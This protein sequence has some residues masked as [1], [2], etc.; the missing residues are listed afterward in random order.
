MEQIENCNPCLSSIN[1]L[2]KTL[3]NEQSQY[4]EEQKIC[5]EYKKGS[6]LYKETS[7]IMGVYC[8]CKGV[9]K[10]YKTGSD[11]KEQ[12][13]AFA[14][15]GDITGYRSILSNEAACTTAE[16]IQNAIVCQIPSNVII[17]LVKTNGNFAL[18]L[19]KLTCRELNQAN[20]FI[21]DIAQK[22]V[23]E[24]LA[25]TLLMLEETFGV[26]EEGYL[27]IILTREE[28]ANIVGTA[29][30][31]VIRLLSEFRRE[32]IIS[33]KGKQLA[34]KNKPYLQKLSKAFN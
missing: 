23:R 16:A 2:F 13:V 34:L 19:L 21:K 7:R 30:E 11:G 24:R 10:I 33:M 15:S 4:L 3:N 12:I 27:N 1:R 32:K 29:T 22:T 20:S 8:I 5:N 17:E 18:H 6:I 14:R 28:I 31:S 9:L 25:E 26:T